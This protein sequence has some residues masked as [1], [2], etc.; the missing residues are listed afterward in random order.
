MVVSYYHK[1]NQKE[2][3]KS[4][5]LIGASVTS[6]EITPFIKAVFI[7]NLAIN[8]RWEGEIEECNQLMKKC[9]SFVDRAEPRANVLI[10]NYMTN[11]ALSGKLKDKNQY[12]LEELNGLTPQNYLMASSTI[13]IINC[14]ITGNTQEGFAIYKK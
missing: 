3:V 6:D 2:K 5:L 8:K 1:H 10:Q 4:L 9:I 14:I 7:S 13:K 12:Q 11:I